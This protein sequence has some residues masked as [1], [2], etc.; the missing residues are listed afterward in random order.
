MGS[1]GGM[2]NGDN[3]NSSHGSGVNNDRKDSNM[4]KAKRGQNSNTSPLMTIRNGTNKEMSEDAR[5]VDIG[6]GTGPAAAASATNTS[7]DDEYQIGASLRQKRRKAFLSRSLLPT[8][9]IVEIHNEGL[10]VSCR[11]LGIFANA[12]GDGDVGAAGGGTSASTVS[13][14]GGSAKGSVA[15]V[16]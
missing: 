16:E 9:L 13:S 15:L 6:G 2:I 7:K 14:N 8:F 11:I 3:D 1:G 4:D 5:N 12:N 10:N